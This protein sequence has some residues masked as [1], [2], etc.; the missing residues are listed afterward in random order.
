MTA[1][2]AVEQWDVDGQH[3]QRY[4]NVWNKSDDRNAQGEQT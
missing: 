3:W 2:I 4:E 1:R